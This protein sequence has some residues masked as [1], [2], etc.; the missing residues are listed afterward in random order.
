MKSM[1]AR[2]LCKCA[3]ISWPL[4]HGFELS[5]TSTVLRNRGVCAYLCACVVL[6]SAGMCVCARTYVRMTRCMQSMHA[7]M[8]PCVP[9]IWHRR[10]EVLQSSTVIVSKPSTKSSAR[11]TVRPAACNPSLRYPVASLLCAHPL[12]TLPRALAHLTDASA[13]LPF[14]RNKLCA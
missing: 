8:Q 4:R 14:R 3:R 5:L 2:A 12:A 13:P 11:S 7:D 10:S 6:G 1:Y 9:S